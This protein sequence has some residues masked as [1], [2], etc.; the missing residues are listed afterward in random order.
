MFAGLP[1]AVLCHFK[2]GDYLI[3]QGDWV[4]YIY[5]VV[6]GICHGLAVTVNGLET[7][8][9]TKGDESIINSLVGVLMP[10]VDQP[11]LTSFV[12][13]TDC[14]CYRIPA[15]VVMACL[16]TRPD[17]LK[18]LVTL[19]MNSYYMVCGQL[20]I[21]Q[22]RDAVSALT[23]FLLDKA[24]E[25]ENLVVPSH[26]SNTDIG[27]FLGIHPVTTA[28]ILKK[29]KEEKL[30]MRA[31]EGIVILNAQLLGEYATGE[32]KLSYRYRGKE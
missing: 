9:Y 22:Q 24:Q 32:K 30:I 31:K 11:S 17:L 7:I 25:K 1:Q 5:Y 26:Y 6:E 27:R 10:F 23:R 12:A 16:E 4:D 28:K 29:L 2:K 20:Q 19:A 8:Y 13:K 14:L 15:D 21:R 18:E 3:K